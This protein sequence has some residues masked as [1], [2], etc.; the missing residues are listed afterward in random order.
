MASLL[1]IFLGL[2]FCD[3]LNAALSYDP[4]KD[5]D[6]TKLSHRMVRWLSN[7]ISSGDENGLQE[8]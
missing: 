6:S 3:I 7:W 2:A 4:E 8:H 1:I 5:S